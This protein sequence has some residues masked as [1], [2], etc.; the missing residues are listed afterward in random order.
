MTRARSRAC[1]SAESTIHPCSAHSRMA[2]VSSNMA[3]T[4]PCNVGIAARPSMTI[5][6]MIALAES[7]RSISTAAN[8]GKEGRAACLPPR[9]AADAEPS[10]RRAYRARVR[11]AG[12]HQR[13]QAG[14][15]R[16]ATGFCVGLSCGAAL[17]ISLGP[18]RQNPDAI[19]LDRPKTGELK[20]AN[21]SGRNGGYREVGILA[22]IWSS[23]SW[24]GCGGGRGTRRHRRLP[25]CVRTLKLA[26]TGPDGRR[27][28]RRSRSGERRR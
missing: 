7:L 3:L 8:M 24:G 26:S 11:V 12:L 17:R 25:P 27:G 20:P 4:Q 28:Q 23:W 2:P 15:T 6:A 21:G 9:D 19:G 16:R 22:V 1:G 13:H 10:G 14:Q 5:N 18:A